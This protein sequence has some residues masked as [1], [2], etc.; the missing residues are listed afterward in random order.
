MTA[1]SEPAS[2]SNA[3]AGENAAQETNA[4]VQLDVGEWELCF[5]NRLLKNYS[6]I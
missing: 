6:R 3:P 2:E 1:T 5:A 4:N